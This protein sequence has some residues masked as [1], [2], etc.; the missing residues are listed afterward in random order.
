MS[1]AA[2]TMPSPTSTLVQLTIATLLGLV[3]L[4]TLLGPGLGAAQ[5]TGSTLDPLS[6]VWLVVAI[7]LVVWLFVVVMRL[8]RFLEA[9]L[10]QSPALRVHDSS[11]TPTGAKVH[12]RLL[13]NLALVIGYVLLSEAVLRRPL[14][15]VLGVYV[16]PSLV[17]A[18]VATVAL[19]LVLALLIWLYRTA[20]PLIK[21]TTWYVLDG[22]LATSGSDRVQRF[23]EADDTK[24]AVTAVAAGA[25][26]VV[27]ATV[28]SGEATVVSSDERNVR[29]PVAPVY[30]ADVTR[31][32]PRDDVEATQM[33][34]GTAA[35]ASQ[36]ASTDDNTLF[37]RK[38]PANPASG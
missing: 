5:G 2:H 30:D 16:E 29:A 37:Q 3:L 10:S 15:A 34:P 23:Y 9:L 6:A 27:D 35:E 4:P 11:Q 38:P 19:V 17:D 28:A 18:V 26:P 14:S 21:A 32:A 12:T 33:A 36:L 31:L 24:A 13:T 7:A 1:Q 8:T 22:V 25:T 20:R